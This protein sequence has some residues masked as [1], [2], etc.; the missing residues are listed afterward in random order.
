MIILDTDLEHCACHA[1]R[2][3]TRWLADS[4]KTDKGGGFYEMAN[5]RD[6]IHTRSTKQIAANYLRRNLVGSD[7]T[8]RRA[9]VQ[10]LR[11]G[12]KE[13]AENRAS[14]FRRLRVPTRN[15]FHRPLPSSLHEPHHNDAPRYSSTFSAPTLT[16][17]GTPATTVPKSSSPHPPASSSVPTPNHP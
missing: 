5:F 14:A 7:N 17:Q 9:W 3:A 6:Q 1:Y 13:D 2:L 4:S 8:G 11:V 15:A 16:T 12:A 10:A